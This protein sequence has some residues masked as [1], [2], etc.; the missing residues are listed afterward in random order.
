MKMRFGYG[1]RIVWKQD[2]AVSIS[3]DLSPDQ[4]SQAVLADAKR[5]R[6]SVW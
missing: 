2:E 1:E 4:V 3:G 5:L 6:D